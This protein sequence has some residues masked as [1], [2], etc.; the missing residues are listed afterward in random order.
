MFAGLP[1][2]ASRTGGIPELLQAGPRCLGRLV[3]PGQPTA[4][5]EGITLALNE[6]MVRL[7]MAARA[8]N[9]AE[10]SFTDAHMVDRTLAAYAAVLTERGQ[11][12]RT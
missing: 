9:C 11:A 1:I 5:A 10:S 8:R 7:Q 3:E 12:T 6:S 4:L 2:V